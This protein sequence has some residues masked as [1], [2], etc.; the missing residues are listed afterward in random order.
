[1]QMYDLTRGLSNGMLKLDPHSINKAFIEKV[2]QSNERWQKSAL[3][4]Q[5]ISKTRPQSAAGRP[6]MRVST[7][8]TRKTDGSSTI[9][10]KN[11]LQEMLD[12]ER[13]MRSQIRP[14]HTAK[15]SQSN[16][17]MQATDIERTSS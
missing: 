6:G 10:F 4:G 14:V 3:S 11:G 15:L 5:F 13:V 17:L 8:M 2:K 1:M 9:E 16:D 12:L 7:V